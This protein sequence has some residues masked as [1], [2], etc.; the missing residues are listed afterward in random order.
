MNE[1]VPQ[2]AEDIWNEC[3]AIIKDQ[4]SEMVWQSTFKNVSPRAVQN[5]SLIVSV[6]NQFIKE[7]L[8]RRFAPLIADELE[9]VSMG[10]L[11]TLIVNV[12][13]IEE[14]A[15]DDYPEFSIPRDETHGSPH[16]GVHHKLPPQTEPAVQSKINPQF[17]FENFISGPSNS[18]THAA[19]LR[20]AEEPGEA[21]N[22]LYIYGVTGLGKTH[23]LGAI[24]NYVQEHYPALLVYLIPTESFMNEFVQAIRTKQLYEFKERYRKA[25][26]LLLDDV[27]FL[28]KKETLQSELFYT[29]NA[30]YE[31]HNQ[32]VLTSDCLPAEIPTIESRLR[33]RFQMG[34][35]TDVQPPDI[36]TRL[37]I[38][39]H[40][41]SE[42][43]RRYVNKEI[44][45]HIAEQV[46]NNIRE[47]EGALNR[48]CAYASLN[49]RK[50]SMPEAQE[51]LD[52]LFPSSF[53][54][55]IKL[56]DILKTC[57]EYFHIPIH[58]ITGVSRRQP[59]VQARHT[60]MYL[61]RELTDL[62]FPSIAEKFGGRD[63]TTVLHATKK[64]KGQ[65]SER[66][67]VYRIVTQ[68]NRIIRN[69]FG[70]ASD[71]L[72]A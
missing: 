54:N 4:V 45:L 39:E 21:Y 44:L 70:S 53:Q 2:H 43:H 72:A 52:D 38:L 35:I 14:A 59:V 68:L 15:V 63:H 66:Q 5:T 51:Q 23:L 61:I 8:E 37:A 25:D 67:E 31:A 13:V 16:S 50:I 27:Q 12:E 36:E 18:F 26:V 28:A 65:M 58:D 71:D 24:A 60:A 9:T 3:A 30:L 7:K 62:S 42:A 69:R 32:I 6:P 22:P 10:R 47:L 29:F 48:I 11:D 34:L 1:P 55:S 17:T 64:I 56:E 19:A 20:V 41:I 57:S 40:K 33:S 49:N 46:P